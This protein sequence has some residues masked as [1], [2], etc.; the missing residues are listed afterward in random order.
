[1]FSIFEPKHHQA[2]DQCKPVPN[3]SK[4]L[5]PSSGVIPNPKRKAI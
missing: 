3:E 1:M 5:M 4:T 2:T